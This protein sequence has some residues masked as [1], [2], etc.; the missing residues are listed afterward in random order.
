M[1]T[2]P[3][4]DILDIAAGL[5]CF[6]AIARQIVSADPA[7]TVALIVAARK[8][9]GDDVEKNTRGCLVALRSA[10][11]AQAGLADAALEIFETCGVL[12]N[13]AAMATI[14]PGERA[15]ETAGQA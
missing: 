6:I 13:S 14:G 11:L 7:A 2:E 3:E 1:T 9:G 5:G 10:A 4:N 15:F 8:A 12:A